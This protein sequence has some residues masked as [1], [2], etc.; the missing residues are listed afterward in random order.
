MPTLWL[1]IAATMFY[2]STVQFT[3]ETAD[4]SFKALVSCLRSAT[5]PPLPSATSVVYTSLLWSVGCLLW[6]LLEYGFHRF[7]FHIDYYLPDHRA[8]IFLHFMMHG[9]HHFLPMVSG[10]LMN[11]GCDQL[12][13]FDGDASSQDGLRLVMPPVLFFTLQLPFTTLAH[14]LFPS[15]VAKG[16]ISGAFTFYVYV[17]AIE[18]LDLAARRRGFRLS[19]PARAFLVLC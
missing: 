14:A 19:D 16:L 5:I 7:V 12:L 3:P 10:S 2:L 8:A 1:P 9:I 6:T 18:S 15:P 17:R 4:F 11:N 13:T